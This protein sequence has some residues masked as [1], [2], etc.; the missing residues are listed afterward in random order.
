MCSDFTS[1]MCE[2]MFKGVSSLGFAA[3]YEK[4][5]SVLMTQRDTFLDNPTRETAIYLLNDSTIPELCRSILFSSRTMDN[6][7]SHE[8]NNLI[9]YTQELIG[10]TNWMLGSG[11]LV[12][13]SLLLVVWQ[14]VFKHLKNSYNL[15]KQMYVLLPVDSLLSNPHIKNLVR[16]LDS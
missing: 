1:S 5:Y 16:S 12:T 13:V 6:N 7:T 9:E 14:P 10:H 4:V 3:F 11:I 15:A 2:N 8:E